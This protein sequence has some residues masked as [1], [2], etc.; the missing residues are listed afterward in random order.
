MADLEDGNGV[1]S[2]FSDP[3][4]IL[5]FVEGAFATEYM[6]KISM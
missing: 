4:A 2:V 5:N 3:T 1:S 6:H